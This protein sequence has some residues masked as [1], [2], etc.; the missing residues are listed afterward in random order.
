MLR[1]MR[2]AIIVGAMIFLVSPAARADPDPP[3]PA[4]DPA[5]EKADKEKA[6]EPS[7]EEAGE[8]RAIPRERARALARK[9]ADEADPMAMTT[10]GPSTG[11][12]DL[13]GRLHPITVHMPLA[14]LLLLV[15]VDLG[16][17]FL[18]MGYWRRAGPLLLFAT[19]LSSIPAVITGMMR[20]DHVSGFF[21]L[22]ILTLHQNV[23][24]AM[25]GACVLALIIRVKSKNRLAGGATTIYLALIGVAM[26]LAIIGG[27]LG[28]K[29]VFG[30]KYL[31]F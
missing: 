7:H 23:M 18:G 2:D 10:S 4:P 11:A 14:W 15:L 5:E 8:K 28:A 21:K 31:P 1:A 29:M 9:I 17:F 16:T 22:Q 20:E 13:I 3:P 12:A 19:V 27:H 25:F 26:F 6:P 24:L 30:P